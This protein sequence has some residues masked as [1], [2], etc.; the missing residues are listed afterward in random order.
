MKSTL[1][2]AD[3]SKQVKPCE[4]KYRPDIDGLRALAVLAVVVYHYAP[5]K[6][7]GGFIG[8]DLF[9][10]ISGYLIT[11]ILLRSFQTHTFSLLDFYRRRVNRIFPALA[12]ILITS[13]I[14]GWLLL[15]SSEYQALGK[16][17]AAGAG[18]VQNLALWREAG[19][20]D[21]SALHKPLLHLWSLAVEEQFYIFWPLTLWLILRWRWRVLTTILA[22]AGVSFALNLWGIWSHHDVATFYLPM[23]RAWELMAGAALAAMHR[24]SRSRASASGAALWS[25]AGLMLI[26]LGFIFIRPDRGFPGFWGLLPVLGATLLIHAGPTAFV[27]QRFLSLKPVVWVGL[28]SYPLYLWHWVLW[29]LAAIVTEGADLSVLRLI[30]LVAFPLS[31]LL[32]WATYRYLEQPIRKHGGLKATKVLLLVMIVLG[33]GG[34]AI[35]RATAL[36]DRPFKL[37]NTGMEEVMARAE[38]P[39]QA[40]QCSDLAA[41]STPSSTWSCEIGDLTS[42]IW[43]MAY[44]DSHAHRLFPALN[45]YG[46]EAKVKVVFAVVGGC[47]AVLEVSREPDT[48]PSCA[49]LARRAPEFA[50]QHKAAAVVLIQR[51]SLYA[52]GTTKPEE[53]TPLKLIDLNG[54]PQITTLTNLEILSRG[55]DATLAQY[56]AFGIPILLLEDSPQQLTGVLS[57][58]TRLGDSSDQAINERSVSWIEHRRNQATS[59]QLLETMAKRYSVAHVLNIDSALCGPEFCPLMRQGQPLYIDDDH[60]GVAGAAQVYPLLAQ[61]L[62]RLLGIN[63]SD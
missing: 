2:S 1:L 46:Q 4:L 53:S 18:F 51:W 33:F 39:A 12:A 29:S 20:F 3:A 56:Q 17:V 21:V 6:F 25:V 7:P 15:F 34:L 36:A 44:G 11:G 37:V 16:H 26:V 14:A 24:S 19:Y 9:F 58:K 60:L 62:N 45:R 61:A 13:L 42:Q 54:E 31:L 35:N 59:N 57:W 22:I 23:T 63:N 48:K 38:L 52:I 41:G 50:H 40:N 49:R 55:L 10:V 27:N 8:V 32:A 43:I 47:P 5:A 30:K 28:I